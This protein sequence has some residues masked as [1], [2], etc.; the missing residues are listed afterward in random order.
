MALT[1]ILIVESN[2]DTL[3]EIAD[4]LANAGQ[5]YVPLSAENKAE[6]LEQVA[7]YPKIM[8]V[9]LP[10]KLSKESSP[11][12][13]DAL[14]KRGYIG[15]VLVRSYS[16]DRPSW[17]GKKVEFV[18]IQSSPEHLLDRVYCAVVPCILRS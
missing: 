2:P 12:V 10:G 9:I 13:Y 17:S 1:E 3:E 6:A 18:D 16:G 4:V 8:L 7:D 14:R 11:D 15:P 5:G